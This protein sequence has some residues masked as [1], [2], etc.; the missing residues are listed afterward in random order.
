[1]AVGVIGDDSLGHGLQDSGLPG[2]RRSHDHCPLPFPEW[3]EEIDDAIGGVR[4]ALDG[5]A[6]LQLQGFIG[7]LSTQLGKEGAPRQFFG[8]NPIDL[9]QVAEWGALPILGTLSDISLEFVPGAEFELLN[10]PGADIDVVLPGS[11][12]TFPTTDEARASRKNFQDAEGL[13][14]G[15]ASITISIEETESEP[16]P[17]PGSH[18]KRFRARKLAC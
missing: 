1:M 5:P 16:R 14:I 3:A 13:F 2:F 9:V 8:G 15:H 18:T 17:L 6:A 4:A 11:V 10:N 7:V 12:G